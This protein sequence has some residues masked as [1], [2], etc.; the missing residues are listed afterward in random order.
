MGFVVILRERAII[1]LLVTVGGNP[2]IN[3]WLDKEKLP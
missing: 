3:F 2:Q 1:G